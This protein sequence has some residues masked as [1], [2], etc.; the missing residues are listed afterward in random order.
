L[1]AHFS[2]AREMARG[3]PMT[4]C[5]VYRLTSSV[6]RGR[7]DSGCWEWSVANFKTGTSMPALGETKPIT[8]V[9][10]GNGC[11]VCTS[12]QRGRGGYP[13]ITQRG[14]RIPL[15]RFLYGQLVGPIPDGLIVRHTC[16]NP[17]CINLKHLVLGTRADNMQDKVD[18][19]RAR[20]AKHEAHGSAKLTL[21]QIADIRSSKE[22]ST[23]MARR[24]SVSPGLV[25]QIRRHKIWADAS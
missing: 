20:A 2:P 11:H 17:P 12:H 8:F 4:A 15:S 6:G 9:L 23:T 24:F 22:S 25:R 5:E 21:A 1:P 3:R 10:D 14:R 7:F 13:R 16:D 19:G 18:R